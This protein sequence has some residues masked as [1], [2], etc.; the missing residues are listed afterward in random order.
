MGINGTP[1]N[2]NNTVNGVPSIFR[3]QING[4]NL[5]EQFSP[6]VAIAKR[7]VFPLLSLCDR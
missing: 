1:F 7:R 4:T 6:T 3:P 2:D 5:D